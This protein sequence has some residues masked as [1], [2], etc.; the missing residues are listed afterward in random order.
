MMNQLPHSI[1]SQ[2]LVQACASGGAAPSNGSSSS[3]LPSATNLALAL[4]SVGAP[5]GGT[6]KDKSA[7]DSQQAFAAEVC[8]A[9]CLL[10]CKCGGLC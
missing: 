10:G 7:M 4:A 5:P 9:V 3:G 1:L 8:C 2:A 6:E